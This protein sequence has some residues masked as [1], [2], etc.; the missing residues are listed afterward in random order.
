M[1]T[2]TVAAAPLSAAKAGKGIRRDPAVVQWGLTLLALG[3]LGVFIV[4]PLVAV[5]VQAFAKGWL[6]YLRAIEDPNTLSA[7]KLSLLA[8]GISVPLNVVFGV[9]AA[10]VITK[11]R[12]K[13]KSVLVSLIDIPFGVSP[14]IS[15]LIFVLVFGSRG[16]VGPWLDEPI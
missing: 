3:A 6:A 14:V 12:F 8:V 9:A 4:L 11:F 2:A 15:G 13:G 5:F 16:W 7:A 1:A 10:W